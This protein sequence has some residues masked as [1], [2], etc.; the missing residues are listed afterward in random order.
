MMRDVIHEKLRSQGVE[1]AWNEFTAEERDFFIYLA[2]RGAPVK[3]TK[4][5]AQDLC[6]LVKAPLQ[7]NTEDWAAVDAFGVMDRTWTPLEDDKESWCS[8]SYLDLLNYLR[9]LEYPI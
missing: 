1:D 3:I 6:S 8:M 4:L 2:Q 5:L 9:L 7:L